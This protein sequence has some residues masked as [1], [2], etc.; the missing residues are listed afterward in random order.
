MRTARSLALMALAFASGAN[1]YT[2]DSTIHSLVAPTEAPTVT[3]SEDWRCITSDAVQYFKAPMA[4]GDLLTALDSYAKSAM[5]PCRS[6]V[7]DFWG[8]ALEKDE[9]CDFSTAAPTSV[10]SAW[11]SI[12]SAALA[13]WEPR[14]SAAASLAKECPMRWFDASLDSPIGGIVLNQTIMF[15]A[16]HAEAQLPGGPASTTSA[17]QPTATPASGAVASPASAAAM[18]TPTHDSA[19]GRVAVL[20]NWVVVSA[21][22]V[23]VVISTTF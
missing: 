14:S 3:S 11:S 10:L 15:A 22:L 4:T 9:W 6:T 8:C 7:R 23:A 16:C 18:P 1:A 19:Q 5:A 17:G 21:G 12:G 2:W 20:G 13:F